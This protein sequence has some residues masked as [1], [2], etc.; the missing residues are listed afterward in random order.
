MKKT[1]IPLILVCLC[2]GIIF[3]IPVKAGGISLSSDAQVIQG[4]N[5]N[6]E[7]ITEITYNE[8][9]A[10]NANNPYWTSLSGGTRADGSKYSSFA[11]IEGN[12]LPVSSA[13]YGQDVYFR[14]KG[15]SGKGT[16]IHIPDY[17]QLP[18]QY[19]YYV[20]IFNAY[21]TDTTDSFYSHYIQAVTDSNGYLENSDKKINISVTKA[22]I[23]LF[24]QVPDS[25]LT[26][27]E[28]NYI[29][30]L[31]AVGVCT[32]QEPD[33]S[34]K[35]AWA[36]QEY[37]KEGYGFLIGHDTMYGYGGVNPD[38]NYTPDPNSTRTPMYQLDTKIDGH[39]NMNWL[40]GI[41]KLYTETSPY[42]A[43]SMILNMGDYTDKSTLYGNVQNNA[44]E[45]GLR[46]TASVEGDPLTDIAS[47]TP[48]NF[49]Y[50]S[51]ADGTAI[52]D[53]SSPIFAGVTHTNQQLAYGK[54]WIDF[55]PSTSTGKLVTD[56]NDGLTGTNNFYLTTNGNFGMM[57]IGHLRSNLNSTKIDECRILANTIMYLSQRKPCQVCQS[58]Q[59]NNTEFHAVT[60]IHSVEE[61]ARIG[62]ENYWFTYPLDGCYELVSDI[63][64]PADW[65]PI[66]GFS[67]HFNADGHTINENGSAVFEQKG[68][69][70]GGWNL[71]SNPATGVP[72]IHGLLGKTTGVARLSGHLNQL[73]GTGSNTDYS[74]YT[75]QVT[76][77]DGKTY[78]CI[79]DREG[80]Y[81]IS[82]LP[83]TAV[84]MTA[85]VF[86]RSGREVT[87]YGEIFANIPADTWNANETY[88][89]H[90]RK[91]DARAVPNE[92]VYE[93]T[94]VTF[95]SGMNG[96]TMPESIVWQYRYGAG[97]EWQNVSSST[98]FQ[99]T[100]STP[101]KIDGA[102]PYIE[103]RLTVHNVQLEWSK[104]EFRAVFKVNGKEYNTFDVKTEGYA[105]LLTVNERPYAFQ[106]VSDSSIWQGE[107]GW[108]AAR[109]DYY[110]SFDDGLTIKWQFRG[111]EDVVWDDLEGSKIVTDAVVTNTV[112]PNG[113]PDTGYRNTSV[114][115]VPGNMDYDKY[116]FRAV[117][118]YN[119]KQR[120]FYSDEN[121]YEGHKG[122]LNINVKS[123]T[124]VTQPQN[125][126]A[127]LVGNN[128]PG[129]YTYTAEF[130][131]TSQT[132]NLNVTWQFK[133]NAQAAYIDIGLFDSAAVPNV[134]SV[135]TDSPVLIG[136]NRYRIK[137]TLTLTNPPKD[138][139]AGTNHYYFR[140]VADD[141]Q[142]VASL[143]GDI[144]FNY[145]IDIKPGE[146]SVR[147]VN[148][149]KVYTY[150]NLEVYAP[151]GVQ[152]FYVVYDNAAGAKSMTS[153][154]TLASIVTGYM[155]FTYN[156][157]TLS[158]ERVEQYLR[159]VQFN[160][161]D[162][163]NHNVK[164]FIS[165][166][167]LPNGFDPYSGKYYEYVDAPYITWTSARDAA[168]TR[169]NTVL[170]AYGRLATIHS[171]AQQDAAHKVS[172]GL[173]A[174][175]GG[176]NDVRY[177]GWQNGYAWIDG[178][179]L[180]YNLMLPAA[181]GTRYL[182]MLPDGRWEAA[183]N[184]NQVTVSATD[185]VI[186]TE[187]S[188]Q[189]DPGSAYRNGIFRGE[190]T[191][192]T[193]PTANYTGLALMAPDSNYGVNSVA[194]Q[195][196][197]LT[198]GHT[199]WIYGGIG[200]IGESNGNMALET[201]L[202]NLYSS[203]VDPP[204]YGY[205]GFAQGGAEINQITTFWGS[206]GT[207][208]FVA[209]TNGNGPNRSGVS[210]QL[211]HLQ[212]VDLTET[213]TNN[214][215]DIPSVDWLK[216][217][218][219]VYSGSKSFTF[220][221]NQSA[222]NGY[223]VEYVV[224]DNRLANSEKTAIATDTLTGMLVVPPTPTPQNMDYRTDTDVIFSCNVTA[225]APINPSNPAS[226]TFR[227]TAQDGS[228]TNLVFDKV[229]LPTGSSERAW[230]KYHIPDIEGSVR[231]EISCTENVYVDTS[232]INGTVQRIDPSDPPDP[233]FSDEN[234][235]FTLP[236][237][238]SFTNSVQHI[239][240]TYTAIN[241]DGTWE[242][243]EQEH[244]AGLNAVLNIKPDER[245]K[246][247]I[248]KNMK[249]GYGFNAT[250]TAT[251][252]SESYL[253]PPQTAIAYFPEFRYQ[254]YWRIFD[255]L[256]QGAR[257]SIFQFPV[258]PYSQA[259]NRV[260]F[261]PLWYP[262]DT[263]YTVWSIV[264][265]MWTPVGELKQACTDTLQINGNVYD[266]WYIRQVPD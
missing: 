40:M 147:I 252:G 143:S 220:N 39:W 198:S 137:T 196:I 116:Q 99:A 91:D 37:I 206:T 20:R 189:L 244:K 200:E 62:D 261:T 108:F 114:L 44:T 138:L 123:L 203:W 125:I 228:I 259:G 24:N 33:L 142:T 124:C 4:L 179:G 132:P 243:S 188:W 130:E 66:K 10:S 60:R 255:R 6:I 51:R 59:C 83:C 247:A 181:A 26:D 260:H 265:D 236:S 30:D 175:I 45:S 158:A 98:L 251:H 211:F 253:V 173:T 166:T 86:D 74:R 162:S 126:K 57:Q 115:M 178:S 149:M 64:L 103:T 134:V 205:C 254:T 107:N 221:S 135:K 222:V 113:D 215:V 88:Q 217:N 154:D 167:R 185:K 177:N 182:R 95:V 140:A 102:N 90:L 46:I 17:S 93:D 224:D 50:A 164:W 7:Y 202:G 53:P 14:E 70:I 96:T 159:Q 84:D 212:V 201:P 63:T 152:S 156:G 76:G 249:S 174:W 58:Q 256:Q 89:L 194:R 100:V 242:Y 230:V 38:P 141:F 176:T 199:Y 41:N 153:V 121:F 87:E 78:D 29:Y 233:Q 75:V 183:L 190:S 144:S 229:C 48:I 207:H 42:K 133:P 210:G 104:M 264:R 246:T 128:A 9:N 67:G 94:D 250:L 23:N 184:V 118:S 234:P 169:Y 214:G 131:Y 8:Q 232:V 160:I 109:F 129:N 105:G 219:G 73:F 191:M 151:N 237:F 226:V 239:W 120:V 80:K 235:G 27:A 146:P 19:K 49:P 263:A 35:A 258:N 192:P 213:F 231:V 22:P 79:T 69:L 55:D 36:L 28:G 148:G 145:K 171:Q 85:K 168:N 241:K 13:W 21:S 110:R 245:V 72:S 117:I 119:G 257:Q 77:S 15:S 157:A 18:E 204:N 193:Q 165:D 2:I 3:Y 54:V 218:L 209:R 150:P 195:G 180:D 106:P 32:D 112:E 197:W 52:S 187:N 1:F 240:K 127:E 56:R 227:V 161:A 31:V 262:D 71:G 82:N 163:S 16:V 238:P 122:Q 47:R 11:L 155:G 172:S 111:G 68:S 208:Q 97:Y 216:A 43:A 81:V 136:T 170:Q 101:E 65:T 225:L 223:L 25:Y 12:K 5:K 186:W 92:A 248:G 61:L 266:D 34:G 139:D